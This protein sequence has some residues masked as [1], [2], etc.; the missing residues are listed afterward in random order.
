M[1]YLGVS[2]AIALLVGCTTIPAEPIAHDKAHCYSST[3]GIRYN[4]F[5][6]HLLPNGNYT[7]KLQGDIGTWGEASGNW[8]QERD[9]ITLAETAKD[10]TNFVTFPTQF[11]IRR[12]GSMG[13]E[14]KGAFYSTGGTDLIPY[15]CDL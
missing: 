6:L 2:I 15:K 10:S 1:K 7:I 9:T 4:H 12:N 5:Y 13:F 3:D 14:Y 8:I 11:T